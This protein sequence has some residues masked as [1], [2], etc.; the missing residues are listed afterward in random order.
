MGSSA[1]RETRARDLHGL[2][3]VVESTV[4]AITTL[5]T[6]STVTPPSGNAGKIFSLPTITGA[7][8]RYVNSVTTGVG[9]QVVNATVT[10]GA[11]ASVD[12]YNASATSQTVTLAWTFTGYY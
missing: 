8:T 4:S 9:A 5:V 1:R 7:G 6:R 3:K 10:N 11:I 12:V 2:F